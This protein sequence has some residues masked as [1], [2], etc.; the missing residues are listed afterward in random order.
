MKHKVNLFFIIVFLCSFYAANQLC[1]ETVITS[2]SYKTDFEDSEEREKW[3]LN[4][5]PLGG[6][7]ANKWY[8]G[9]PGANEGMNGLYASSNGLTNEYINRGVS[10][11]AM[12]TITLEPGDYD[13]T[14]DWTAGGLNDL[15]GLYV[16]WIPESVGAKINSNITNVL[17]DFVNKYGVEIAPDEAPDSMRLYQRSWNTQK[18]L[19][20]SDGSPS[21]LAFVWNNGASGPR[22][23]GACIDNICILPEG[24]CPAPSDFSINA[25]GHD[26]VVSWRGNADSY[27]LKIYCSVTNEWYYHDGITAKS[28]VVEDLEE[29]MKTFYIRSHCD[30][31][32][33][34]WTSKSSF[35][36]YP[37]ARCIN[38]LGLSNKNC[39]F[40]TFD[41]PIASSGAVD[42][43]YQSKFSRHTLHYDPNEYD[44]IT[45]GALKTV[46]AGELA[47]VRLGNWNTGREAESVSYD[48]VVDTVDGALLMLNY[49]IVM[50]DPQHEVNA[51]PKFTL[52]ITEQGMPLPYGCGSAFFA[53]GHGMDP[54]DKTWHSFSSTGQSTGGYW[55]DWT[56]V[57]I[58]LAQYHGK[59]L[60]IK[61][62]TYD[63]DA[64]GHFGYAYFTLGCSSGKIEGL[65]CGDAPENGFKGPD[66]FKYRWYL[67]SNPDKILSTEQTY[68]VPSS[69]TL[70]YFLDVIQP[71]NEDCY[72]T[73]QAS[74]IARWPQASGSY[75]TSIADCQNVV[76]FTNSSYILRENQVT[77]V[78]EK[79]SEPCENFVWDFGDGTTSTDENP[80]HIYAQG[81][82][83]TVTLSAGIA[84][85]ACMS[86]MIFT[87]DLPMLGAFT[88]T[89]HAAICDGKSYSWKG[90]YLFNPGI[91]ADSAVTAY[92]CDSIAVL[93]LV[94]SERFDTLKIDTICSHEEYYFNGERITESGKYQAK[95]Q[96]I[97]GCDSIIN[98]D[99]TVNESLILNFDTIVSACGDDTHLLMPY[100]KK[101]GLLDVCLAEIDFAGDKY[102]VEADVESQLGAIVVPL[103]EKVAPG[104]YNVSL[105]FGEKACGG[106][107][108]N[109]PLNI[110]YPKDILAQRWGDVLAVK[111]YEYNG[112]YEFSAFQ[113]YKNGSPIEG[114]ISSIYYEEDGLDLD[115]E[116]AVLLTR[117]LDN[118]SIMTCV[119]KLY[120][121]ASDNSSSVVIFSKQEESVDVDSPQK[122][123][124]RIWS[125]QGLL[126]KELMI[127]E[128]YSHI[129]LGVEGLCLFEFIYENGEK[130]IKQVV[131]K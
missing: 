34:A 9:Q 55:K 90:E 104:Y 80:T 65:S 87:L 70:T 112:N 128:G 129:N 106:E 115:A 85:G 42:N 40:G 93:N 43:G 99:I 102:S 68:T 2:N 82:T 48:Y 94:V 81:G 123:R 130:E 29:G 91:Y 18:M 36:F 47:S 75:E 69:D 64:S 21:H 126:L 54:S 62:T 83:Y 37:N 56:T 67:P 15:D 32:I 116:Y 95:F 101:S 16:C 63:C 107:V 98:L 31:L 79:T 117:A 61:L 57:G 108:K 41:N 10:V 25:K 17:Q 119:A 3:E 120:N 110:Y 124:L 51:Q 78:T 19:V 28:F 7:C 127:N 58:N 46:P 88:D 105:S 4:R 8:I 76:K 38:Y 118:V 23:P 52:D 113:W 12:R 66:G 49:A 96:T 114:A 50:E 111:N 11:V 1:A 121:F 74:A 44:P 71:T 72:F 22:Q 24:T 33:G 59:S 53:A 109:I 45:G 73:L 60:K 13:L 89:I 77:G 5:G 6:D 131:V 103:P 100:E 97:Y 125:M 92:G 26:Y 84:N 86:D 20:G 30:T 35:F 14:F 122:A 27:D 39:F